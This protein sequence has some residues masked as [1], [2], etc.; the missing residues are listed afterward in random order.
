MVDGLRLAAEVRSVNH[1]FCELSARLP[2]TLGTFEHEARKI[3]Q[4]RSVRGKI[5][6]S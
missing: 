2:R 6:S 4:E 5:N 3:V 1:R